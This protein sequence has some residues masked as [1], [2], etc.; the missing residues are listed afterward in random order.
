MFEILS[1]DNDTQ[2]TDVSP[3]VPVPIGAEG[4]SPSISDLDG[5]DENTTSI[6]SPFQLTT[7]DPNG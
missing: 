4:P 1:M 3:F 7:S 5:L 2:E 6:S